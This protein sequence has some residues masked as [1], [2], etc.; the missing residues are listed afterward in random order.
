MYC[1]YILHVYE[2]A[3]RGSSFEYNFEKFSPIFKTY[4]LHSDFFWRNFEQ[5]PD[6]SAV[7]FW[8]GVGYSVPQVHSTTVTEPF[9]ATS[10]P[11]Y[12]CLSPVYFILLSITCVISS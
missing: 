8:G 7:F 10:F 12:C 3:S 4:A 5:N 1:T 11:V 6:C 9:A 2:L